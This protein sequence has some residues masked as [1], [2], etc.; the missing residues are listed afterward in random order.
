MS[1]R[2]PEEP[3]YDKVKFECN[4]TEDEY[5]KIVEKTKEY[6]YDG[7]IFQAVLSRRFS[8]DYEG[9][10]NSIHT[11][12][13]GQRIHTHTHTPMWTYEFGRCRNHEYLTGNFGSFRE[14]AFNHIPGCRFKTAKEMDEKEDEALVEDLL[15]DE[16]ELSEH[17]MLVDLGRNDLGRISELFG[18]SDQIQNDS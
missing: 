18:R 9:S 5:T 4:V 15:S 3:I 11:V 6:I 16:K 13:Y 8:S 7:D 10:V 1:R 17:N 2:I 12:C 14:W